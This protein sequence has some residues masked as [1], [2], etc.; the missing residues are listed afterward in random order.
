MPKARLRLDLRQF[1][2]VLTL[3]AVPEL[4]HH[5]RTELRLLCV[6][7]VMTFRRPRKTSHITKIVLLVS[8]IILVAR[9]VYVFPGALADHQQKKQ[10]V[11]TPVV[12]T[13]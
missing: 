11:S 9:L 5:P 1:S 10:N 3:H 2:P 13:K 8:F 6:N 12:A 4:H 7:N